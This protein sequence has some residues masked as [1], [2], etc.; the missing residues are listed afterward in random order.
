MILSQAV[1]ERKGLRLLSHTELE[2]E[3]TFSDCIRE[4]KDTFSNCPGKLMILCQAVL[5]GKMAELTFGFLAIRVGGPRILFH[6][7]VGG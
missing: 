1:L 3:D 6:T 7:V 5:E 2:G 4:A